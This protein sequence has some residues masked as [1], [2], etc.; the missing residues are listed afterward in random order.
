MS[1]STQ[2]LNSEALAL[3]SEDI[4]A[5]SNLTKS[6]LMIWIGQK[7]NPCVPLYNMIRTFTIHGEIDHAYFQQ[8]FCPKV[9]LAFEKIPNN[10]DGIL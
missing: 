7:L 8:A 9:G 3:S 4:F 10:R 2:K 1:D 5:Q 6:Q